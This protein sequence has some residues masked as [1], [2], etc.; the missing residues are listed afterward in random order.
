MGTDRIPKNTRCLI[1]KVGDI[2]GQ[3][4]HYNIKKSSSTIKFFKPLNLLIKE[5]IF[6]FLFF[7]TGPFLTLFFHKKAFNYFFSKIKNDTFSPNTYRTLNNNLLSRIIL[8]LLSLILSIITPYILILKI[9]EYWKDFDEYDYG[10]V[11]LYKSLKDNGYMPENYKN[12]YIHVEKF[13]NTYECVDGNHRL[14]ILSNL[15]GSHKKIKVK[16]IG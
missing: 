14:K 10:W 13:N 16:D 2:I 15:Y 7:L 12:G 9:K 8:F 3:Y 1:I 6:L 11:E 5:S 4:D